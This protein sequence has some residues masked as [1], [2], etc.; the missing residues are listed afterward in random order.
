MMDPK[1]VIRDLARDEIERIWEIDR[2]EVID[3]VYYLRDGELIL[4]PEHYDMSGWPAGE[5][6]Q[7]VS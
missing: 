5:P 6:E 7:I 1:W 2:R 3:R 4:E